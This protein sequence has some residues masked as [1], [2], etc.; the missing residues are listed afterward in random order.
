MRKYFNHSSSGLES[1]DDQGNQA[2]VREVTVVM[3]VTLQT[4]VSISLKYTVFVMKWNI[5]SLHLE[6]SERL[7]SPPIQEIWI[8]IFA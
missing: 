3:E 8:P 5:I 6:Q 7:F 1:S 2:V 4:A